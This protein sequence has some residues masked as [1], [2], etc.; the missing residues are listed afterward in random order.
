VNGQF[1]IYDCFYQSGLQCWECTY[2]CPD[3]PG[4]VTVNEC[5]D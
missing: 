1:G 3:L 2:Y 5:E 4:Q